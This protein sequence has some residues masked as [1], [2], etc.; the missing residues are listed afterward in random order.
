MS[1]GSGDDD[2][3]FYASEKKKAMQQQPPGGL[4]GKGMDVAMNIRLL[5]QVVAFIVM[6]IL[7][8]MFVSITNS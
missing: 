7:I 4:A 6:M 3:A 5:F 8:W 2:P 1:S